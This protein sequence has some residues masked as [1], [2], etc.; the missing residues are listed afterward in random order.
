MTTR[1]ISN[2]HTHNNF[3]DGKN[4]IEEMVQAAIEK[5]ILH[6]GI[7]S[8]AYIPNQEI[9]TMEEDQIEAYLDEVHR[10]KEKYTGRI[11]I[12]TGLEI[13]F[14]DGIGWYP[15]ILPFIEEL[16]Y[17]IGSVHCLYNGEIGESCY[18]DDTQE[19]FE[20]G[21]EN[22]FNGNIQE[23]VRHYYNSL[24]NMIIKYNPTIIGHMDIIKKN[25]NDNCFFN[26]KEQWYK[27]IIKEVLS[28]IKD[29]TS[30]VEVNTGGIAR[31][32]KDLL[33]P[34]VDILEQMY[35]NGLDITINGDSHKIEDIDFYYEEVYQL[36]KDI[37]YDRVMIFTDKGWEPFKL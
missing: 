37:G 36:I 31:Y 11:H 5:G 30:I 20:E 1:F 8:H 15:P 4:T 26:E 3:C 33:Y 7:S 2:Y 34:S 13:D 18:V 6:L 14:F 22:L 25:N 29:S 21:V 28:V 10:I 35:R 24:K 17:D 9:W 32:G 12:Y 16:D 19:A 27:D 23:A